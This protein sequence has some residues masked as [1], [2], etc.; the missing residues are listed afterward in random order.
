MKY[1]NEVGAGGGSVSLPYLFFDDYS[2]DRIASDYDLALPAQSA[3]GVSNGELRPSAVNV[4]Q[5]VVIKR[6]LLMKRS[7]AAQVKIMVGT[8]TAPT[9]YVDLLLAYLGTTTFLFVRYQLEV[10]NFIIYTREG[11]TF[12]VIGTVAEAVEPPLG[13]GVE[14]WIRAAKSGNIVSAGLFTNDPQTGAEPLVKRNGILNGAFGNELIPEPKCGL[15][16]YAPDAT[17]LGVDEFRVDS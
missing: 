6:S 15:S 3:P 7:I 11:P 16:L 9:S 10:R 4:E 13:V 17:T 12:T 8:V 2:T 5:A 1:F 14:R